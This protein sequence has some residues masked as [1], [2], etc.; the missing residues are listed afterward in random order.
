[1]RGYSYGGKKTRV[2]TSML[3]R[4]GAPGG[5]VGSSK[6]VWAENRA[7]PWRAEV[8]AADQHRFVSLHFRE[9]VVSLLGIVGDR[10]GLAR[11]V[12]VFEIAG[13]QIVLG[14]ALRVAQCQRQFQHRPVDRPPQIDDCIAVLQQF[15]GFVAHQLPHAL[16]RGPRGVVVV[17]AL[18]PGSLCSSP[19]APHRRVAHDVLEGD[20][21]RRA[22]RLLDDALAFRI[23]DGC[24]F[25]LVV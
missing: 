16:R 15:L 2:R 5:E 19:R 25:V 1:M 4:G 21:A 12:R 20:D 9:V 17:D 13:D 18:W 8:E 22:G 11:A 6:P 10:I 14:E 24:E 23:V 3:S 7:A